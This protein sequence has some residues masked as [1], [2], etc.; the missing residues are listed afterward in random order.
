MLTVSANGSQPSIPAAAVVSAA[1]VV[2]AGAASVVASVFSAAGAA[3][4]PV[5]AGADCE[6]QA[7]IPTTILALSIVANNFF[8]ISF[9]L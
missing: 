1:S 2:S 9:L 3:S 8:F 4:S 5:V 6:P 7:A